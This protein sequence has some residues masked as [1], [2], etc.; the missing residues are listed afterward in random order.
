MR[1]RRDRRAYHIFCKQKQTE[2]MKKHFSIQDEPT[3]M[4]LVSWAFPLPFGVC[5]AANR[6]RS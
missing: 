1:K 4:A 3:G 5:P 6:F 2:M